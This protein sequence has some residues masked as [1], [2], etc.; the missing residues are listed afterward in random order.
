MG[1]HSKKI[2]I[3]ETGSE[4]SPD[5]KVVGALISDFP[6]SKAMRNK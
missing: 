5:A 1:G 4:L 2:A 3:H 6:A